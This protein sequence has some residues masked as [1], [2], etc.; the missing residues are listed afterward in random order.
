MCGDGWDDNSDDN[1][2]GG[3]S[4]GNCLTDFNVLDDG[5]KD[6]FDAF[7]DSEITQVKIPMSGS[8]ESLNLSA[9]AA[10]VIF[11]LANS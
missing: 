8:A 2:A 7:L 4:E 1:K 11:H 3:E 9:A 6:D 5:G 10:I